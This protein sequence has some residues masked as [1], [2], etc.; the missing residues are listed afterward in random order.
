[1]LNYANKIPF[2]ILFITTNYNNKWGSWNQHFIVLLIRTD[3]AEKLTFIFI[4][5]VIKLSMYRF[6]MYELNS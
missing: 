5:L 4:I 6:V 3:F 2:K 1:M